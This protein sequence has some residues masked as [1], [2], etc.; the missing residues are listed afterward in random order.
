M[1]HLDL[2]MLE[3]RSLVWLISLDKSSLVPAQTV[4]FLGHRVDPVSD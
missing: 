4:E 3:L 1:F 2:V